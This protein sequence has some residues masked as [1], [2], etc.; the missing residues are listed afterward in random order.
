MKFKNTK[1]SFYS[2]ISAACLL[3]NFMIKLYKGLLV[4]LLMKI[5]CKVSTSVK[6]AVDV[7]T[8]LTFK[9]ASHRWNLLRRLELAAKTLGL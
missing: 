9:G 4:S 6:K 7:V 8:D 3:A 1:R 5:F 2:N